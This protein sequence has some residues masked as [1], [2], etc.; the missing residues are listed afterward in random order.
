MPISSQRRSISPVLAPFLLILIAFSSTRGAD[1][2]SPAALVASSD[3]KRL[4]VAEV[5]VQQVA[6]VD[7]EIGRPT[8]SWKLPQEPSGLAIAPDGTRLFVT[9]GGSEGKVYPIDLK[10]THERTHP[11]L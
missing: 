8:N 1:Y 11:Q 3:G 7:L 9:A 4:Y 6:T 2:L 5:T 10:Q